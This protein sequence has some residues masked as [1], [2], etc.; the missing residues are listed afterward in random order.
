MYINNNTITGYK[1]KRSA[2]VFVVS[3]FIFGCTDPVE[4]GSGS[5]L[6][7]SSFEI[8]GNASLAGWV[9]PTGDSA[10]VLF[11][12]DVPTGGGSYSAALQSVNT[13]PAQLTRTVPIPIGKNVFDLSMYAKYSGSEGSF[14]IGI[15]NQERHITE[16]KQTTWAPYHVVYTFTAAQGDSLIVTLSGGTSEL[17]AGKTY[18]DLVTLKI[19]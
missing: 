17:I 18:F 2:L 16:I 19:N 12:T 8:D 10:N 6:F 1:M 4:P 7:S 3:L 11:D 14:S 13:L 9:I 5:V 15:K